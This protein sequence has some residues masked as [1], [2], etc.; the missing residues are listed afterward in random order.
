M[1]PELGRNIRTGRKGPWRAWVSS[2][3]WDPGAP[4]RMG[5]EGARENDLEQKGEHCQCRTTARRHVVGQ[6]SLG[7]L[8]GGLTL[9]TS[10]PLILVLR[11]KDG[12]CKDNPPG[13]VYSMELGPT[14]TGESQALGE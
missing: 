6:Q 13:S 3:S 4:V 5:Q 2:E 7:P 1:A 10:W 14:A 11:P 12:S 8:L 9:P